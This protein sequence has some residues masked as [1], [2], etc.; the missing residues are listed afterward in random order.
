[1]EVVEELMLENRK[2]V[3]VDVVFVVVVVVGYGVVVVVELPL[4]GRYWLISL[5]NIRL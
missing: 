1:M 4:L 5:F 2:D 3:R